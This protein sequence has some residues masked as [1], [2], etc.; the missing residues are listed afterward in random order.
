MVERDT[1]DSESE[2]ASTSSSEEAETT[3][4]RKPQQQGVSEYEKQRMSRIAENRARLEALGL[5]K[6]A[7]SFKSLSQNARRSD[8]GKRK[9]EDDDDDEDYRPE[10]EEPKSDPSSE[11]DDDS[12]DEDFA[13]ENASGSRKREVG[14][15]K[16]SM[17][18]LFSWFQ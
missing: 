16:I 4:K 13:V 7:S 14:S 18:T 5:P 2:D 11:E 9:L 8:K 17:K 12:K 6:M 15:Q 3:A 10:K 1:S